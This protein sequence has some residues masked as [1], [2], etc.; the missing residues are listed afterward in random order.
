MFG[1]F[2]LGTV[3]VQMD[4]EWIMTYHTV[5]SDWPC[6][7]RTQTAMVKCLSACLISF[8]LEFVCIPYF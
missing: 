1:G 3:F 6:T 7:P 5:L 8:Y 2:N 4:E